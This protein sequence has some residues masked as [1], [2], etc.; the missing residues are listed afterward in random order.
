[1]NR[2]LIYKFALCVLSGTLLSIPLQ[3]HAKK[4][5]EKP[6]QA[7]KKEVDLSKVS[8]AFGHLIG[9]NLDSLGF[10]FDMK[11]VIKGLEDSVAG[12]NSPMDETECVQAIS[13][14]QE[15]AFNNLSSENLKQSE[16]FMAKNAKDEGVIELES[17][18]LQYRVEQTG[19]GPEV[20]PHFTPLIRYTGRFLDGKV[21]ASAS[22]D[23]MISL[24]ETIE[25]FSKGIIGM[26]EGEKR[27]LFIHPDLGYGT[28]GYLPPNSL[29]SFEIE[30]I[31]ANTEQVPEESYTT[32]IPLDN[33]NA[34]EVAET[35]EPL[36]SGTIR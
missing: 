13:I 3:A 34:S 12:K 18:K 26:H 22:E 8:E 33:E 20:Q 16:E 14:V 21:F 15:N 1:M 11:Q 35:P 32:N 28:A 27:T 4:K 2:R 19:E 36:S 5:E 25:G 17:G 31:K 10:D 6:K 7:E 9:K 24:D 23:E 30:V 29:L